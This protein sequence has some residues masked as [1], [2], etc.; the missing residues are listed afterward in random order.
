MIYSVVWWY[1]LKFTACF[2][3]ILHDFDLNYSPRIRSG[4][5]LMVIVYDIF[6]YG[7]FN[8]ILCNSSNAIL[9]GF[10]PFIF[11][12]VFHHWCFLW[13]LIIDIIYNI[14]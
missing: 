8:D 4:V 2:T 3:H 11:S 7:L 1:T 14:V 10:S 12:T 9:Y 13:F 5:F 6:L